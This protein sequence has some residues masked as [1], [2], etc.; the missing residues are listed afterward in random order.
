[1][2]LDHQANLLR[3]VALA[4]SDRA[5]A[6]AGN[7]TTTAALS[8]LLHFLDQPTIDQLRRVLGL[9]PSGAVRLVDRLALAILEGRFAAGDTVAV[10]AADGDLVL[11]RAGAEVVAPAAAE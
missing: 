9:T 2:T 8:A 11:E 3:A 4:I 10:D 7:P 5:A 1:M 6:S